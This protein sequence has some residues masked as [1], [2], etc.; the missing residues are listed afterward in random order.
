MGGYEGIPTNTFETM[1]AKLEV[2]EDE[3]ILTD[4]EQLTVAQSEKL[5]EAKIAADKENLKLEK[6]ERK[7]ESPP[8]LAFIVNAIVI[9]SNI[10]FIILYPLIVVCTNALKACSA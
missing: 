4:G 7:A 1:A 6:A 10:F 8:A 3:V 2:G 5:E 9:I